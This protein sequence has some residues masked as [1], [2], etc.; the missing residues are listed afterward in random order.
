MGMSIILRKRCNYDNII[1]KLLLII[2][3]LNFSYHF[4]I[5]VKN[6]KL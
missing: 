1:L 3:S 5:Y 2:K 4:M 6:I